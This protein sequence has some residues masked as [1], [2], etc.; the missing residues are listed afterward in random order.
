MITYG[1]EKYIREAIEG[2]LMQECDFEVELILANDCSPDKTDEVIQ[3]IL[4]NHPKASWIKYLKHDKN[5]GMMPNFLFA[6]NHCKGEF[7]AVCEG[8]D[9]WTDPLKLQKQVGFLEANPDYSICWTKYYVKNETGALSS[10]QEPDWIQH[11]DAK[12]NITID[13]NSIFTPYCTY[14]LTV[15]FKRESLDLSL[16]NQSKYAKDNSLYVMC[17][18][19]GKGVLLNFYSSVYRLHQ[20]GVYSNASEFKQKYFSYLNL[21]EIT[22]KLYCI[23]LIHIQIIRKLATPTF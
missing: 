17:L 11:L 13:L 21:K 4:K 19:K 23:I 20:G 18:G 12:N 8:D 10:L 3:D 9:Y 16:L 22:K 15:L 7:I 2:V 5:I 6:L 1:H 14:T